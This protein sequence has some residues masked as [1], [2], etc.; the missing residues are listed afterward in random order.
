MSHQ[1][2]LLFICTHNLSRSLTAELL[3]RDQPGY[4]VRSAGTFRAAR[5]CVSEE[6]VLWADRVFVMEAHHAESLRERFPVAIREKVMICLD[7]PDEYQPLAEDLFEVL[8]DRLARHL[9]F[10]DTETG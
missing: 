2:K 8:V 1:E 4:E 6:L 7:I 10:E 3:L 5:V 9:R